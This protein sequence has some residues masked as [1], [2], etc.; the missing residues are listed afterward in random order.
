MVCADLPSGRSGLGNRSAPGLCERVTVIVLQ[1]CY[2]GVTLV[3][4]WYH[5][6]VT[7]VLKDLETDLLQA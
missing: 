4:H 2:S 7:V 5:S 1:R 6:D 3:L